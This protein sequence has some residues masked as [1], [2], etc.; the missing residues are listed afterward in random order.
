MNTPIRSR[1]NSTRLV[2]V[3]IGAAVVLALVFAIIG[4]KGSSKPK[5]PGETQPVT[6][7]GAPLK[8]FADGTDPTIGT[9]APALVGKSFDG[10]ARS[11]TPGDGKDTLVLFVAHWCPHCQR[12]VPRIVAWEKSGLV[13]AGL[14]IRFVS[15]SVDPARGNYPASAWLAK[16]GVTDPVIADDDKSSAASAYGLPG[17]PY[18]VLLRGDGT[19]AK[20][21]SGEIE[22]ADLTTLINTALAA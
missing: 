3:A 5:V 11:I 16:E 1:Y 20:R 12:E 14:Q 4:G 13:P 2:I 22:A 6:I 9:K 21:F 19:V 7:T 17:F 10:S 18:F 15:T 8:K